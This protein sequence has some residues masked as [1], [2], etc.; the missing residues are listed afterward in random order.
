MPTIGFEIDAFGFFRP[1]GGERISTSFSAASSFLFS[2]C[3]LVPCFDHIQM[4]EKQKRRLLRKTRES[5]NVAKN[6]ADSECKSLSGGRLAWCWFES[7]RPI[8]APV[9]TPTSGTG[10]GSG[11][12]W[13]APFTKEL[14]R[15]SE[16]PADVTANVRARRGT[17]KKKSACVV[18]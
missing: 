1:G 4:V 16:K 17:D 5:G 3:R 6:C 15:D 14:K 18:L 13:A 10:P 9:E 12:A 8:A 11:V 7:P 2:V